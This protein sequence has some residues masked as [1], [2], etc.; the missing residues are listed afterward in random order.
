MFKNLWNSPT[1]GNA[2]GEAPTA[3]NSES[4]PKDG[5][6]PFDTILRAVSARKRPKAPSE[7]VDIPLDSVA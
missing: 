7:N 6:S 1:D 4:R 3:P 5:K 2:H